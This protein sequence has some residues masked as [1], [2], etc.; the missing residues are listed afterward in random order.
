[1][2]KL[3][4]YYH[5]GKLN[6]INELGTEYT[7]ECPVCGGK[8]KCHKNTGKY[9]CYT[10][11]CS[12]NSIR[13][14]LGANPI[15]TS[16]LP[17]PISSF[18]KPV[19]PTSLDPPI[20]RTSTYQLPKVR[21]LSDRTITTYIFS[22]LSCV[23]RVDYN[24]ERKK[25]LYPKYRTNINSNWTY[26]RSNNFGLYGSSYVTTSGSVL[27]TEGEK[28]ADYIMRNTDYVCLSAPTFAQ[29]DVSYIASNLTNPKITSVIFLP[30]NDERGRK[31][32]T[33][34]MQACWAVSKPYFIFDYGEAA[35]TMSDGDDIV[36]IAGRDYDIRRLIDDYCSRYAN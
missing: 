8:L 6:L 24:D 22:T 12:P 17:P 34:V 32:A 1:M 23:E 27:M 11:N 26:G 3:A 13:T 16:N 18:I 5:A 15:T 20:K 33:A 4:D 30:D 25:E 29:E 10:G 36:D 31:K 35:H 14:K 21:R 19:I 28:C 9:S 7:F 2:F